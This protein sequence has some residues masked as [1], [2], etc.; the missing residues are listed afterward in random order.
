VSTYRDVARRGV[1]VFSPAGEEIDFLPLP[2]KPTNLAFGTGVERNILYITAGR[3][4]YRVATN[5]GRAS[6]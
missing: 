2:E 4:L 5:T 3:S 1:I 6:R